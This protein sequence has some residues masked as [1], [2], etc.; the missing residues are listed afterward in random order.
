M[1]WLQLLTPK[2]SLS[3]RFLRHE[4]EKERPGCRHL[5]SAIS[6]HRPLLYSSPPI[7]YLLAPMPMVMMRKV[8]TTMKSNQSRQPLLSSFQGPF[9]VPIDL[10]KIIIA[11]RIL[12][13]ETGSKICSQ[14]LLFTFKTNIRAWQDLSQLILHTKPL[15]LVNFYFLSPPT[16]ISKGWRGSMYKTPE[17]DIK[18]CFQVPCHL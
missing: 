11:F 1:R 6:R 17:M 4:M 13:W 14:C 3:V 10:F 12:A 15:Q 16:I 5:G 18:G 9:C 2:V 7:C 8:M